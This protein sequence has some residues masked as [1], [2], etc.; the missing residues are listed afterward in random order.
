MPDYMYLLESRLSAEQR[1]AVV[2]IQEL[3]AAA[4]SNLYLVG[5][6]V[7]DLTS[8]MPIRDP[9]AVRQAA[10][11]LG[12]PV[13]VSSVP[14][15]TEI[16]VV[17]ADAN[18]AWLAA[19]QRAPKAPSGA[20]DLLV[21]LGVLLHGCAALPFKVGLHFNEAF[22]NSSNTMPEVRAGE[23]TVHQLHLCLLSFTRLMNEWVGT[24]RHRT[25]TIAV[26][27]GVFT[28]KRGTGPFP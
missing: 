14:R 4:E 23:I 20:G 24:S 16:G 17:Y 26:V 22:D 19:H 28:Q 9:H 27:H 13:L 6:A 5:G 10:R 21:A 8:G 12:K 15:G 7:R 11:L 3:A 1:A 2:R 18:E 25:T